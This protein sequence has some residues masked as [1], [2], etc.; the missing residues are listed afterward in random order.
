MLSDALNSKKFI[1][2]CELAPPKGTDVSSLI[3]NASSLK[4][5]V[6]AANLTDGQG[7]NMRMCPMAAAHFV[8]KEGVDVIWQ[9]T[10]RDRNRI[11]LQAD[12]LG[13]SAIGI[14]NVLPMRGDDPKQG[15]NPDA[16]GVFDL[17]TTE[18]IKMLKKLNDG[19]DL[20]GKELKG[21]TN[22]LIGCTAHPNAPDL[23]KQKETLDL[24]FEIGAG[25]IQ[26]Q[27][28]YEIEQV[29]RFLDSIGE[30][31]KKTFIGVTPL[32]S[33]KMAN[34]MNEKVFGVSVPKK[35]MERL[36]SAQDQKY[37]GLKIAKEIVDELRKAN[38]GGI[39]IM[40]VGQENDLPNIIDFLANKIELSFFSPLVG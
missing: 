32:K 24:R 5:K 16:K 12:C 6:D 29:K 25:F 23:K 3:A 40:A 10:C 15:D 39:H 27:I 30:L 36:E 11:A 9:I 18:L 26:T 17:E 7:G 1:I 20:P 31:A 37:E 4:G 38:A 19:Y 22:F 28:C 21:K 35:I 2:T 8:L 34:F 14:K 33:L 13:A